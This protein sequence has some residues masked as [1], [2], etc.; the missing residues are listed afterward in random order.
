MEHKR[1]KEI[2]EL[3]EPYM[4][5]D[6]KRWLVYKNKWT[7]EI[8][9]VNNDDTDWALLFAES[10]KIYGHYDITAVLKF[11][12]AK[13]DE[14]ITI[15]LAEWY[16]NIDF[17]IKGKHKRVWIINKPLYLYTEKEEEKLLGILNLLNK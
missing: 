11:I 12:E 5:S 2:I 13:D 16:F 17:I 9:I 1:L 15:I 6:L 3:I 4:E 7:W 10:S 8:E 14:Y